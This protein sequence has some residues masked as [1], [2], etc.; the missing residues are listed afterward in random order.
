[1]ALRFDFTMSFLFA[2][3]LPL[4]EDP[5]QV[6]WI[7]ALRKKGVV[8]FVHF[9]SNLHRKASLNATLSFIFS[10]VLRKFDGR[11][12]IIHDH[13]SV[14]DESATKQASPQKSPAKKSGKS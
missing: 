1:M 5:V 11:W 3:Y 12:L 7:E 4:S 10:L 13:T 8:D 6:T 9:P 14:L 2:S